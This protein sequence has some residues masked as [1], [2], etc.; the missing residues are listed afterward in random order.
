MAHPPK[1]FTTQPLSGKKFLTP[2]QTIVTHC[3]VW[4]EVAA[5]LIMKTS[6]A[7]VF[8][9]NWREGRVSQETTEVY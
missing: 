5:W 6:L 9:V 8:S 7:A 1:V 4:T 2:V 3:C